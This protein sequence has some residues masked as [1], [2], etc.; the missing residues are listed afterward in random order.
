MAFRCIEIENA[1]A[2]TQAYP[3]I[4]TAEYQYDAWGLSIE[5]QMMAST[6][7][8]Q[9]GKFAATNRYK[10]NDKEYISDSKLYDYGARHYDPVV[11]RWWAVDPLAE[12]REWLS[13]YNYVQN[14]PVLRIDPDGAFDTKA[15]AK[16]Y[17][18]DN[19]IRTGFFSRNKI[20]KADDGS[21]AINNKKESTSISN[22]KQFGV[23]TGALVT[24]SKDGTSNNDGG[25]LKTTSD[26]FST[27]GIGMAA[28]TELMDY[29]VR[30]L[31]G[32]SRKS[33]D[34]LSDFA[35]TSREMEALG[36]AGTKYLRYSKGLGAVGSGIGVLSAAYQAYNNPTVGNLTRL[37]VQGAAVGAGFIPVV[38]WGIAI[39]IGTA[40]AL[41]GDQFYNSLDKK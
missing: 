2:I 32:L 41:Y 22:D 31:A 16:Q 33:F 24:A 30:D 21:Y 38:G 7:T 28:K 37:A 11:G 19:N 23:T 29:A 13:G 3:A 1:T 39:G 14:N 26:V 8:A 35:K 27:A 25:F 15:D 5:N 34:K 17:A 10:Y 4:V 9:F 40:Y 12:K 20:Q 36:K 6:F 18:E